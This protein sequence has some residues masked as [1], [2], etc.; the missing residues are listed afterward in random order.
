MTYRPSIRTS[1]HHPPLDDRTAAPSHMLLAQ[2][3]KFQTFRQSVGLESFFRDHV[4]RRIL[5][6]VGEQVRVVQL[7]GGAVQPGGRRS[8]WR[9]R[10]S[11]AGGGPA[12]SGAAGRA[13]VPGSCCRA[14]R[15]GRG[16]GTVHLGDPMPG[17]EN[18]KKFSLRRDPSCAEVYT[19]SEQR[20]KPKRRTSMQHP[21][22]RTSMQHPPLDDRTATPSLILLTQSLKF[23][24]FRQSVGLESFFRDHVVRRV[25]VLREGGGP[26]TRRVRRCVR[27][28]IVDPEHCAVRV[29]S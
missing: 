2:S 18:C 12:G 23:Q 6:L 25:L 22:I 13:A 7:G 8:S 28:E 15:W 24:T 10:C 4:V 21:S 1:V 27:V 16:D 20:N 14:V 26:G 5:R 9:E 3:L 19:N 11:W 29:A 17:L